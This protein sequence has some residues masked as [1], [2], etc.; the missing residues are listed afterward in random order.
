MKVFDKT[1][2]V[3]GCSTGGLGF[4]LAKA[5]REQGFYVFTTAR[6]PAKVGSLA[7]EDGIEVL[8][9]DVTSLDSISSCLAHVSKRTDGKLDI[10]VNN[11]GSVVFGPLIHASI[12]EGK[13]LY[14]VNVWGL[15]ALAQ[16][17]SPLLL[18]AKGV[19]LN[20]SSI[21][22]AVPLAWQG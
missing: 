1:V 12:T 3:T 11:A 2:L 22:G 18:N 17:F 8:P 6:N 21:A 19:I 13:T 15:L 16:A 5:F 9:L 20:I 14:D 4:A 7:G 10:L